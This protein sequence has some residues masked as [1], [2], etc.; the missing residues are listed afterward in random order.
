[1]SLVFINSIELT[2]T[3]RRF[4]LPPG[5]RCRAE[6]TYRKTCATDIARSRYIDCNIERDITQGEYDVEH[7]L[8]ERLF[9][10]E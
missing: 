5:E 3:S 1:M 9:K 2:Y 7:I 6:R 8:E 10:D 4:L